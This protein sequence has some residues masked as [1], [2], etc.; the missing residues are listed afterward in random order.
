MPRQSTARTHNPARARRSKPAARPLTSRQSSPRRDRAAHTQPLRQPAGETLDADNFGVIWLDCGGRSIIDALGGL[1]DLAG[2]LGGDVRVLDQTLTYAVA[3]V[4]MP[5]DSF[6][7][8]RGALVLA[9]GSFID[10]THDE[11]MAHTVF[12]LSQAPCDPRA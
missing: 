5:P 7:R 6:T 11:I 1:M 8:F 3:L 2:E 12:L 9:G 10:D 4:R